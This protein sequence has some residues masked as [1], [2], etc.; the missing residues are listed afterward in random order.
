MDSGCRLFLWCESLIFV[1]LDCM[2]PNNINEIVQDDP[3]YLSSWFQ[4]LSCSYISEENVN[5]V[6]I[7]RLLIKIFKSLRRH[8]CWYLSISASQT[9][10]L[11]ESEETEFTEVCVCVFSLPLT[12]ACRLRAWVSVPLKVSEWIWVWRKRQHVLINFQLA[13]RDQSHMCTLN[14]W[15]D[16]AVLWRFC[17]RI[18]R[19]GHLREPFDLLGPGP[20]HL[21]SCSAGHTKVE[22]QRHQMKSGY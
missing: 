20:W 13:Q 8:L 18:V 3:E 4:K 21:L 15:L 6:S 16:P 2:E 1:L 10:L 12:N 9:F 22:D 19:K 11:V 14:M 5:D 17:G 7:S